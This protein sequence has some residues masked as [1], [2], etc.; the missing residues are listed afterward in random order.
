ME[1]NPSW[2]AD[3]HSRGQEIFPPFIEP[4]CSLPCS[5]ASKCGSAK[6]GHHF[7]RSPLLS[8]SQACRMWHRV[9]FSR[10]AL[11]M[12]RTNLSLQ[13]MEAAGSPKTLT[14]LSLYT[15]WTSEELWFDSLWVQEVCV[16]SKVS[17]PPLGSAHTPTPWVPAVLSPCVMLPGMKLSTHAHPVP[18][19]RMSGAVI[20]DLHT[21]KNLFYWL[22]SQSILV[23]TNFIEILSNHFRDR[24]L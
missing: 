22:P 8:K 13:Q 10:Q 14:C 12:F 23:R 21:K 4:E 15:V 11:P 9:L 2:Q 5:K 3:G 7:F 6:P 18:R 16:L 19:L 20:L 24:T 1:L 17:R